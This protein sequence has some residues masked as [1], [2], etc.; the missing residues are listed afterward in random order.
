MRIQRLATWLLLLL[1]AVVALF[2]V[3]DMLGG[4]AA[5]PAITE[6]VSGITPDELQARDPAVY[7]LVDQGVRAGGAHLLVMGVSWIALIWFGVRRGRT[8]AWVTTWTLPLWAASVFVLFLLTPRASD[9][10]PP[11]LISGPIFAVLA[12]AALVA[13]WPGMAAPAGGQRFTG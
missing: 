5:D 1:A 12:A 10:I 6:A 11:P 13:T 7:T 3:T 2:G 9:V 8:W 4:A